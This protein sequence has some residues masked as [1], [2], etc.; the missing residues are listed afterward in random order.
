[1]LSLF[2]VDLHVVV[3]NIKPLCFV[4][5]KQ[6]RIPFAPLSGYQVLCFAINNINVVRTSCE[7]VDIVAR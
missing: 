7:V 5:E 3:N 6:E 2:I 1:M 4:I